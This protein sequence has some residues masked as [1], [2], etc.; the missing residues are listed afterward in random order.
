MAKKAAH[1][2]E[3]PATQLQATRGFSPDDRA[4]TIY[5]PII[6]N[7]FFNRFTGLQIQNTTANPI[8]L[9]VTFKGAPAPSSCPVASVSGVIP[10]RRVFA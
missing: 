2:S 10:P 8:D 9:T 5:A 6:K 7:E 4:T 1:V 3:T